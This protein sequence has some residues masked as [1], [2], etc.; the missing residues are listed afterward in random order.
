MKLQIVRPDQESIENYTRIDIAPNTIDLS[1]VSD[2]ECTSILAN[3]ILDSFSVENIPSLLEQ[4][5]KKIRMRGELIIGGTDIRLFC[6]FVVNDQM[7]E[8]SATRLLGSLQSMTVFSH[9]TNSLKDLGLNIVSTQISGS[10]YEV[11]ASRG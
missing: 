9:T 1:M 11:K 2:N 4:L 8:L 7:D 10:H 5:V 6:K 3:D